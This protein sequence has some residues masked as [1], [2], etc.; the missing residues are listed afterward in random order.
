[1]LIWH[2]YIIIS[3][4]VLCGFSLQQNNLLNLLGIQIIFAQGTL[5]TQ[6]TQVIKSFV[7][8]LLCNKNKKILAKYHCD[9]ELQN[10]LL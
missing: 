3:V 9:Y 8:T 4:T 1:M 10:F 7:Q 6:Q 2:H 5:N